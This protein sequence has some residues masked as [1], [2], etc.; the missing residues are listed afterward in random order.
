MKKALESPYKSTQH[1]SAESARASFLQRGKDIDVML[2]SSQKEE[3]MR[4]QGKIEMKQWAPQSIQQTLHQL[5][6]LFATLPITSVSCERSV[7]KLTIVKNKLRS[8]I[9]QH[10]LENLMILF[11]EN[12]LTDQLNFE[13]VIASMGL[14]RMQLT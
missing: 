1:K 13:S 12:D 7:S 9:V 8:T 5:Y 6:H 2:D 10:R 14:R 11:L 3:L 4:K